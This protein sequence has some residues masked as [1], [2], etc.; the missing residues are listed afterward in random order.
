MLLPVHSVAFLC[1]LTWHSCCWYFSVLYL[2][3]QYFYLYL[4][5]AFKDVIWV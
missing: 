5:T 4:F 3:F 1:C 2:C